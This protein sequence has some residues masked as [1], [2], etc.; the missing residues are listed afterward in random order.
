VTPTLTYPPEITPAG[1][2]QLLSS[3]Y[4]S[5][6]YDSPSGNIRFHLMGGQSPCPGVQTGIVCKAIK[7]YDPLFD[8]QDSQG[9]HQDGVTFKDAVYQPSEFDFELKTSSPTLEGAR[10]VFGDWLDSWDP[11]QVGKLTRFTEIDGHWWCFVRKFRPLPNDL[12]I[13]QRG[14]AMTWTARNDNTF[15]Q[16]TPSVCTFHPGG[17]GGTGFQTLTN[18]GDQPGWASHLVYGPFA[19][20]GIGDGPGSTN[21]ITFGPLEAGQIA[22]ITTL[23]RLRSVVDLSPVPVTPSSQN[24]DLFQ[25]IVKDLIDFATAGNVPPLLQEFEN[26]LGIRP[27]QGVLYSYLTGRF[28]NPIPAKVEGAQPVASKIAV[29]IT[30]G[31]SASKIISSVTPFRRMSVR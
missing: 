17:T 9:A 21:M 13:R 15:F 30:G 1:S 18:R 8:M 4:P 22:L 23:P 3:R 11:K 7:S 10:A 31:N 6:W 20:I 29:S 26:F 25:T 5:W 19:K 24:L 16:S 12:V 28:N 2:Y 14:Q 27:P